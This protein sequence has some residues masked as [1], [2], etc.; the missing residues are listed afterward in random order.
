MSTRAI[1]AVPTAK[2]YKTAWCWCDGFPD[3]LGKTLRT[4]FKTKELVDELINHHSFEALRTK[5]EH[6]DF[7]DWKEKENIHLADESFIELSNGCFLSMPSHTGK[8]VAGIGRYAFFRNIEDMLDQ[9]LNY[10][11]VFKDGKWVTYR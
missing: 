9:D 1:I 4:K 7:L 10:V 2:G 11:Y 3:Q 8:T 6:E 5:K